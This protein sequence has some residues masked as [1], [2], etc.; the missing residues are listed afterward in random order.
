MKK[1]GSHWFK[2]DFHCHSPASDDY[3]RDS[4]MDKDGCSPEQWLLEHMKHEID[5]VVLSDHNTGAWI[6]EVRAA[7][8]GLKERSETGELTSYRDIHII[9][10]VELTA[11]GNCHVLG[12]F[13][14]SFKAENIARVVGS[15]EPPVS[16]DKN[17]QTILGSGVPRII[18]K[19]KDAGGIAI[20]A[21]VDKA[22]GIFKNTNQGE[23]RAAFNAEPDAVELIGSNDELD[24]FAHSLV[25]DL[26]KVKG[27]DAHCREQMGR[28]FTWVKMSQPS[29][30]GIKIALTDPDHCIIKD[31]NPPR[32]PSYKISKMSLKT[33]MCKDLSDHAIDIETKPLVYSYCR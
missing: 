27:S 9:P 12:L 3:P 18:S 26:A 8:V 13:P 23:V 30:D 24:G 7:L 22:K 25:K 20:L 17:H 19:I 28:S 1:T 2:V 21:H 10:A 16:E 5:C 29:F 15:C 33:Y 14:E 6:D 4:E 11:A 31:G 32:Y